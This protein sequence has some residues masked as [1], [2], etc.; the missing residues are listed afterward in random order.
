MQPGMMQFQCGT[1]GGMGQGQPG[2]VVACPH[3]GAHVAI[4]AGQPQPGYTQPVEPTRTQGMGGT[5][6][7]E[8]AHGGQQYQAAPVVKGKWDPHG[9]PVYP[10]D[11]KDAHSKFD[12]DIHKDLKDWE[13]PMLLGCCAA[14]MWCIC[15]F[16]CPCCTVWSQ[17]RRLLLADQNSDNWRY[18]HCCAGMYGKGC[19]EKCDSCTGN[20]KNPTQSC[21]CAC[22]EAWCVPM[23]A[24]HGNRYMVMLHYGLQN[25]CC[26][27]YLFY[28][29]CCCQ[30]LAC[31]TGNDELEYIADLLYYT[32]MGCM[33]AQQANEM[34]KKGYP[35]GTGPKDVICGG[36]PCT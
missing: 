18:Y 12:P 33:T 15:G 6:P 10:T 20:G 13:T 36:T 22:C 7:T 24:A 17:R 35:L 23:C 27:I 16:V 4:P 30:I 11:S 31:I 9:E 21:F 25:T 1:C 14:P 3:C 26:D 19:T 8:P 29:L 34:N 32:I 28:L 2:T 5:R